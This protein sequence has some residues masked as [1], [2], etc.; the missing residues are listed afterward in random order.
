[1]KKIIIKE[2]SLR[3]FK[4]ESGATVFFNDDVTTISGGNG[5]GKS[6]IF[7]A[8]LWLLFGKDAQDRKDYGIKSIVNGE[9]LHKVECSVTGVLKIDGEIIT[10]KRAFMEDWVKPRGQVE[11]VFKGNRTECWWNDAPVSVSEYDNRVKEIID[12]NV[13]KMLTNPAYFSGM[14]WKLQREQLF[15]IA[16]TISDDEIAKGNPDFALLIDKISGKSLS[17]FKR[18]LSA[19]KKRLKS[20]LDEIQPRIDQTQKL[21]PVASDFAA[22]EKEVIR[23]DAEIEK[24]DKAINDVTEQINQHYEEIQAR[25][26]RINALK[27]QRQQIVY[28]AQDKAMKDAF[29]ANAKRRE[30]QEK[31][32]TAKREIHGYV[33]DENS[34]N[35][36]LERLHKQVQDLT[37]KSDSLREEW[38]KE[39]ATTYNGSTKCSCCGQELP[40]AMKE[41]ALARFNQY[42]QT[43]LDEITRN[44]QNLKAQIENAEKRISDAEL[45]KSSAISGAKA[46]EEEL[47]ASEE[48]LYALPEIKPTEVNPDDV[49]GYAELTK[50]IEELEAALEAGAANESVDTDKYKERKRELLRSRDEIKAKLADR[51]RIEQFTKQIEELEEKGNNLSQQIADAEREEYTVQEFV[52]TKVNEC[53]K[54]INGMFKH[55]TFRLYDYTLDGNAI[56]TCIPLVGG[57]PYGG[58][59]TAGQVNAGLDIINTLCQYYGICPTIFLD[60]SES[61][62]SI[63]PV[64]NQLVKL[65]VTKDN[66]LI[67]K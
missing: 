11:Q 31:I 32:N 16:G 28:E 25:Q 38:Y 18:E 23:I 63:I 66:K 22:L 58:A 52:K 8:Y 64:K 13:F 51:E 61:V 15:Q 3:N 2:L 54:R 27:K 47:H 5:L 50:Q 67:I 17:D 53:E 57:V 43:R 36:Q 45:D 35:A 60:G 1:M 4:G 19:R 26:G 42:K 62:N 30:L 49:V 56:E 29:S 12:A 7:D 34:A 59:N 33:Q 9:E 44:G 10:L 14:N 39:N 20:E 21:M 6:R 55:V 46:K 65:V 40:E 48:Q 41:E 37:S 24:A